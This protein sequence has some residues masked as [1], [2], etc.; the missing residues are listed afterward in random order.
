MNQT[1][2]TAYFVPKA[3]ISYETV[4]KKSRFI[5][6]IAPTPDVAAAKQFIAGIKQKYPNAGHHCWA[7]VAGIP[8]GSHVFGFSDDGEP[9]GTAGK[10]MLNVLVGSGLGDICAVVTRYFGGIKLGTGG[11]VRA[12]G[13]CLSNAMQLVEK[14]DKIPE[15]SIVGESSYAH[16]SIIEQILEAYEIMYIDKQYSDKV[17]WSVKMDARKVKDAIKQIIDRT[18]ANAIFEIED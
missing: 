11:L 12:Y 2:Y 13:G 9:N 6:D 16:Q 10:P 8:N 15:L 4:I 1:E 14:V 3:P 18:S 7:H 5:V 17:I